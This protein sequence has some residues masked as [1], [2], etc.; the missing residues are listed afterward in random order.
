[1]SLLQFTAIIRLFREMCWYNSEL[2]LERQ[3]DRARAADLT[4][5]AEGTTAKVAAIRA[6]GKDLVG[7]AEPSRR[8]TGSRGRS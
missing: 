5:T 4:G 2:Q 8:R 1:M 3:L 7:E 6:L